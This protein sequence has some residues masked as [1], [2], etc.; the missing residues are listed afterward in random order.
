[1]T[2]DCADEMTDGPEAAEPITT[3]GYAPLESVWSGSDAELIER[4]LDFYPRTRPEAIP[5]ATVNDDGRAR[6]HVGPRA[7]SARPVQ[8][9]SDPG[10]GGDGGR[11]P[12]RAGGQGQ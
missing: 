5:D 10:E 4:M 8:A 9:V 3:T 1:M 6:D 12:D 11:E 2:D 7:E